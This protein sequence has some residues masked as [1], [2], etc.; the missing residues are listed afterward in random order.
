[1]R[2]GNEYC[3]ETT[4]VVCIVQMFGSAVEVTP[5]NKKKAEYACQTGVYYVYGQTQTKILMM[6]YFWDIYAIEEYANGLS[7][8]NCAN[9]TCQYLRSSQLMT[10]F[11]LDTYLPMICESPE[12]GRPQNIR[13]L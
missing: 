5:L 3:M 6:W 10:S 11:Y 12:Y 9:D 7:F 13:T 1:M 2:A 4:G 8:A